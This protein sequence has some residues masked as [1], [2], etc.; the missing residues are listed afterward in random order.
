MIP[1]SRM[2][3]TQPKDLKSLLMKKPAIGDFD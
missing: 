1:S 2:R 3:L